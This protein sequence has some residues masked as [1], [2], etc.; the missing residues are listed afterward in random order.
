MFYA[1]FSYSMLFSSVRITQ[2][3]SNSRNMAGIRM[4]GQI[5]SKLTF[6]TKAE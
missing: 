2:F 6:K 3:A 1:G 4:Q 5:N